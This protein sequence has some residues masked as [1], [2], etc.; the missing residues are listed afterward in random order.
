MKKVLQVKIS[1]EAWSVL[2]STLAT[3]NANFKSG[4]VS[5]SDLVN[6]M[7]VNAKVDISSLQT[8]SISLKKFLKNTANQSEPDLEATIKVLSEIKSRI[9]KRKKSA[10]EKQEVMNDV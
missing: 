1:E 4:K 5:I 9:S 6:E 3:A 10:V 7:I 2:D 8:K